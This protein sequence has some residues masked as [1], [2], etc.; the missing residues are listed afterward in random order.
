[1]GLAE[2]AVA[3]SRISSELKMLVV[4]AR[5]QGLDED[6]IEFVA[7]R[8]TVLLMNL[9]GVTKEK[10]LDRV[11]TDLGRLQVVVRQALKRRRSG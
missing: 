7:D 4:D 1:M 11:E 6:T 2:F 9:D 8:V 10:E 3:R 5:E